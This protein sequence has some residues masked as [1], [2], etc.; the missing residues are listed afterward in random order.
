MIENIIVIFLSGVVIGNIYASYRMFR[1]DDYEKS[2][3]IFQLL[4]IWCIPLIG[5]FLV[6]FFLSDASSNITPYSDNSGA[7]TGYG[8]SCSE[9]VCD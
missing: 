4:I 8:D 5:I 7:E 1:S 2:Q 9:G 6:L 3:K